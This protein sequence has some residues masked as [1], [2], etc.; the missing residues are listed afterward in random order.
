MS[1]YV[2]GTGMTRFAKQ[3]DRSLRDLTAEAV[4][5]ALQHAGIV[6]ERVEAAYFG[7]AVAGSMVGQ[8]MVA[9]EVSLRSLGLRGIPIFNVENACASASSAFHIAWQAVAAGACDVALAVGAEKLSHPDKAR[10]FAAIGTAVDVEEAAPGHVTGRSPFMD[11]YA[12][13]ARAYMEASGATQQDLARVVVKNQYHGSLNPLAQYGDPD[14]TIEEVLADREIVWPLT[15]RMCSPIS[16]GAAAAVLVSE[17]LKPV[18]SAVRVAATVVRANVAP[19]TRLATQAATRAYE[20]ASLDPTDVD[21]A[22]VHDAAAAAELA[23]YE[24]LGWTRPGGGPELIRSG[25]TRLGGR[26]PVNVS[27]GLLARGHPIGATGLGQLHE[28][29]CQLQGDAG[30]RQVDRAKVALAHNA[31][32]YLDGDSA[33]AVVTILVR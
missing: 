29:V 10:S 7:N 1:V 32:G 20:I 31:G 24:E 23:L 19:G 14:L 25:S 33:V 18:R 21:V 6:P 27:G 22:E 2:A 30:D 28:L 3:P 8:E 15:L 13:E 16:D 5:Q 11:V 26:L 17:R 12:A 9:G 4:R